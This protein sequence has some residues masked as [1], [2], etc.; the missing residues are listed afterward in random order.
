MAER[1]PREES[2]IQPIEKS[3]P[4]L[5]ELILLAKE[6]QDFEDFRCKLREVTQ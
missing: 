1:T 2:P 5:K 3:T 6:S 4:T